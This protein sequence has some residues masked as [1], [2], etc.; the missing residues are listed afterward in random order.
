M[1]GCGYLYFVR[2]LIW[3]PRRLVGVM[4]SAMVR[5]AVQV[6]F[7]P[8]SW[9]SMGGDALCSWVN[10]GRSWNLDIIARCC[11]LGLTGR[12]RRSWS[13]SRF[14]RLLEYAPAIPLALCS[15]TLSVLECKGMC[16]L[17]HQCYRFG[18]LLDY[19]LNFPLRGHCRSHLYLLGMST[20]GR[21]EPCSALA[22]LYVMCGRT[23]CC[24]V[25]SFLGGFERAVIGRCMRKVAW[26]ACPAKEVELVCRSECSSCLL[27]GT[28]WLCLLCQIRSAVPAG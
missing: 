23:C 17:V 6:I 10:G 5:F 11:V 12:G 13:H 8:F 4:G 19:A 1:C 28:H 21:F 18:L 3:N 7:C 16:G 15:S 27:L 24:V 25:F 2:R 22:M 20:S 26:A 9:K 14:E